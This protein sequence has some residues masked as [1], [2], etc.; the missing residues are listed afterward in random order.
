MRFLMTYHSE[1]PG[2]PN[3]EK[4]A[5][6]TK[7]AEHMTRSGV[8]IDTGGITPLVRSPKVKLAKGKLSVTD[9][10]FPET[11]EL[12]AGFALIQ[13][14]TKAEAVEWTKRFLTVAGS[15]QSEIRLLHEA[16]AM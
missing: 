16:P 15:G 2:P 6:I 5:A 12:I 8:L 9:G 13:V 4:I 10:P 3:P 14:K 11:K 1:N 7:F